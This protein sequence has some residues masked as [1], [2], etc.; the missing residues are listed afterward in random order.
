MLSVSRDRRLCL[1]SVRFPKFYTI[2]W[3]TIQQRN[4]R[5]FK[6]LFELLAVFTHLW[7]VLYAFVVKI[8]IGVEGH[9]ERTPEHLNFLIWSFSRFLF[10]ETFNFRFK[11]RNVNTSLITYF[12]YY[13]VWL[14]TYSKGI[15]VVLGDFEHFIHDFFLDITHVS[16]C[17]K[18]LKNSLISFTNTYSD[19]KL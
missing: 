14:T 6:N 16:I 3:V 18:M 10:H 2:C 13:F 8:S 1:C 12:R 17:I 19:N 15:T 5:N 4:D 11:T 9:F 7:K